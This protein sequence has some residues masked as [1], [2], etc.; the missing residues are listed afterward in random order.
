MATSAPRRC[1]QRLTR[2]S[3][4]RTDASPSP[5]DGEQ[6]AARRTMR[7]VGSLATVRGAC[8]GCVG[9]RSTAPRFSWPS[10]LKS[11]SRRP[12]IVSGALPLLGREGVP[13]SRRLRPND[14]A[15]H[16]R[17]DRST[18]PATCPRSCATC[19]R[20]LIA[21]HESACAAGRAGFPPA[22]A[23]V[24]RR[25]CCSRLRIR[26]LT[27]A[28]TPAA[29]APSISWPRLFAFALPGLPIGALAVA[30]SVYLPR[31]YASHIGLSLAAVGVAFMAVRLVD[32]CFDPVIGVIMDRTR[33]RLG[34]YRV[35]LLGR[36]AAAR[37]AG[38]HAVPGAGRRDAR[39]PA[40][41]ALHLLPRHL[42]DRAL[43][44]LVGVGDRLE[45]P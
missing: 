39:L 29:D 41:L 34:R 45:V 26:H 23:P 40:R 21:G 18:A 12:E 35:W 28:S 25:A 30:L 1:S 27:A 15:A 24:Q 4:P 19:S 6:R 22:Q 31:Y 44:R 14:A 16:D 32:M 42:G 10:T 11:G 13:V 38:L 3:T 8:A 43:A 20:Q 5:T 7:R 36:R 37:H 17:P 9:L 33:T 2:S